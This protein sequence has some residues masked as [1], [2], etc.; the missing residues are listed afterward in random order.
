MA[1]ST[2]GRLAALLFGSPSH[3]RQSLTSTSW[4]ALS[5]WPLDCGWKPEER[6]TDIPRRLQNYFQKWEMNWGPR[7]ETM[8]LGRPCSRKTS[9]AIISTSS[10]AVG[11]LLRGTRW[12]ILKKQSTIVRID[13][14]PEEGGRL[15]IKIYRYARP[16][17]WRNRN[18]IDQTCWRLSRGLCLAT[19]MTE[20]NVL[21]N[22]FDQILPPKLGLDHA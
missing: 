6:L 7:S 1:C 15:V 9:L 4:L 3:S 21:L 5:L 14:L 10:L 11:S 17:T 20:I 16:G 13:I 2:Q 12:I 19:V 18:W 22:I 8:P